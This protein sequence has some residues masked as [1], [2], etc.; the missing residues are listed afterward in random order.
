MEYIKKIKGFAWDEFMQNNIDF[1]EEIQNYGEYINGLVNENELN[2]HSDNKVVNNFHDGVINLLLVE[3]LQTLDGI[4]SLF[5]GQ[6]I[7]ISIDLIRSLLE[8][9]IYIVYILK[10]DSFIEKRAIAYSINSI[11][12]KIKNYDKMITK[13]NDKNYVD[14]KNNLLIMFSKYKIYNEVKAEWDKEEN[15]RTQAH[16]KRIGKKKIVKIKWYSIHGGGNNFRELC[17]NVGLE[18]IYDIYSLYSNKIHGSDAMS[19]V[20]VNSKSEKFIKNP[21]IPFY[22]PE[23]L[24]CIYSLISVVYANVII[25]FLDKNDIVNFKVWDERIKNKKNELINNW[26]EFRNIHIKSGQLY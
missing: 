16:Y 6:S 13:F 25:Y 14:A 1:L 8:L 17:K 24:E 4:I 21:K 23:I 20:Y 12:N 26:Q 5:K 11:N 18:P 7:D 3:C 19:G 15:N 9:T 10:D 22:A 2:K